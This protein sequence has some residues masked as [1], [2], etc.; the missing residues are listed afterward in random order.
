MEG[1]ERREEEEG[2]PGQR[3]PR[4]ALVRAGGAVIGAATALVGSRAV[5]AE[6]LPWVKTLIL[7]VAGDGRT[8]ALSTMRPEGFKRG[9][10]FIMNGRIYGTGGVG[11]SGPDT[12]GSMGTWICRGMFV[13]SL[14]E[15]AA[16]SPPPFITATEMF[17]FD[18]GSA[19][20]TEGLAGG[21]GM[22]FSRTIT[23][24]YGIY[25]DARGQGTEEEVA[26]NMTTLDMGPVKVPAANFR[27]VFTLQG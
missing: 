18:D 21:P 25:R 23:G 20:Y 3:V 5:H 14:E 26:A 9:D 13:K 7:E 19:L 2:S 4:R 24:G 22:K 15:I 8:W 11:P 17:L 1:Y 10:T 16:G 6:D 12:P 27:F